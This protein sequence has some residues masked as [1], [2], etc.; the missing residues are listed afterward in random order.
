[1]EVPSDWVAALAVVSVLAP[2]L[3]ALVS[4]WGGWDR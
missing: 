4:S 3:V 2:A 1:M